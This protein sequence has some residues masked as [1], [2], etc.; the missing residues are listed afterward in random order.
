MESVIQGADDVVQVGQVDAVTQRQSHKHT[1]GGELV[2]CV[3]YAVYDVV[4]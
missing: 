2:G 4:A 1:V 3:K